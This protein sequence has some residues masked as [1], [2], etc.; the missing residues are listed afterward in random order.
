MMPDIDARSAGA[1]PRAG[2]DILGVR[3]LRKTF[4]GVVALATASLR[5]YRL[6][7]VEARSSSSPD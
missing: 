5:M 7:F 2:I 3:G 1:E 6:A 4:P